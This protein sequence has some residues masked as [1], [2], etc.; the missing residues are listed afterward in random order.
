MDNKKITERLE[1]ILGCMIGSH[2]N[3]ATPEHQ[4]ENLITELK[5]K[6]NEVLDLVSKS[7]NEEQMDNAYDKG[8]EDGFNKMYDNVC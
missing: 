8:F 4:I 1:L 6:N 7:F 5:A 2:T 3:N